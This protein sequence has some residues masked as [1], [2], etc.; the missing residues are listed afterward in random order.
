MEERMAELYIENIGKAVKLPD[1]SPIVDECAKAGLAVACRVGIC[2]VCAIEVVSGL[3]NLSSP[4]SE[5]IDFFGK[6]GVEQGQ[7]LAC[8]CH[9]TSGKVHIKF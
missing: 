7:R 1:G 9:I 6:K 5:E 4:T 8:K 2:G 3:E